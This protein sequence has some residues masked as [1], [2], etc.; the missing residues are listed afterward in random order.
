[1]VK[2]FEIK[3]RKMKRK[4]G[5]C[6][7]KGKITINTLCRYLPYNL[8]DYIVFHEVLHRKFMNH[9]KDFKNAIKNKFI[10]WK[11]LEENLK[12][13]SIKIQANTKNT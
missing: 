11:E 10:K 13:Y 4:W 6:S 9:G 7:S 2:I 5:S 8:I 3:F 12:L 1:N